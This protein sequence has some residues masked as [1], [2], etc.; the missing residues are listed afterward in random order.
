MHGLRTMQ[1]LWLEEQSLRVRDDVPV[2]EPTAGEALIKVRLAG[3]CATD[4]ELVRGYYPFTGVPGHEFVG[5]VE[6]APDQPEWI[7]RRVVGEINLVCGMCTQCRAD[8]STHCEQR[9]VLGIKNHPGVFAE[10]FILPVANLHQVPHSLPDEAA[11]F[12]EPLAAALEIQEQ[13]NISP[14][15]RVLVI[16]AGRLGQLIAQTLALTSCELCVI[17]RH[18]RQRELL[19]RCGIPTSNENEIR[20]GYWDVVVEATG[21]SSGF[22]LARR[23][24]RP[25]GTI[26][27][28]STFKGDNVVNLSSVVVDE[29]TLIGSRCGPFLPAL[30]L[31]ENKR[32]DPLPLVEG[33]YPLSQAGTAFTHADQAGILKILIDPKGA[34]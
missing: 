27:L 28:K 13:I 31:L 32:I 9:R 17:V 4:L 21:S 19:Q 16:G 6:E 29:I 26:L 14:K 20:N 30:L 23:A 33:R 3:I 15:N 8:R 1:A 2:P 34:G 7:G 12:T 22:D 10:Y 18:E 11:I 25:R 5:E 24:I